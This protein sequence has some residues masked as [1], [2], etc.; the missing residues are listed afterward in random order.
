M[1][2]FLFA[3][4]K[5]F[6]TNPAFDKM[7]MS[8]NLSA[9]QQACV[10]NARIR[11]LLRGVDAIQEA[12]TVLRAFQLI[13]ED[14][15]LLRPAGNFAVSKLATKC[16]AGEAV[17]A[18]LERLLGN[19]IDHLLPVL[20]RYFDSI[21]ITGDGRASFGELKAACTGGS[22]SLAALASLCLDSESNE[23]TFKAS[24]DAELCGPTFEEFVRK[25][26]NRGDLDLEKLVDGYVNQEPR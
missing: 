12:P 15:P 13:Y 18:N 11:T 19:E 22:A 4:L 21:N 25:V 2:A 14:M 16:R 20:R 1:L 9:S 6:S 7:L 10:D 5:G 24:Y 8:V 23:E 26:V 3:A 17:H